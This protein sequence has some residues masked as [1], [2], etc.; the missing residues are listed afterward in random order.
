MAEKTSV[1]FVC[2][3]NAGR[4][5]MAEALLRMLY[6]DRYDVYSAGTHPG[7]VN[8]YAVRALAELGYDLAGHRSKHIEEFL[9]REIDVVVTVCDSARENCPW[10]PGGKER[11][12]HSFPDPAA[13]GGSDDEIMAGVREIRDRMREWLV[14]VFGKAAQ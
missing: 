12:H 3:H 6:G 14:D 5:Q 8:P 11:I 1:L 10:F 13:L 2:T 7:V 9:E 4:S